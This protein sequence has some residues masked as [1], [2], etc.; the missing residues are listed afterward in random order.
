MKDFNYGL[1][2]KNNDLFSK[3]KKLCD[4]SFIWVYSEAD[5]I[6]IDIE[7]I[8]EFNR[9]EEFNYIKELDKDIF[10]YDTATIYQNKINL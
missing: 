1:E 9:C 3:Y 6:V 5:G 4:G 2:I 10:N 8:K 7:D